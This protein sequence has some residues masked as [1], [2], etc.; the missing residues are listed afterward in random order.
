MRFFSMKKCYFFFFFFT[1]FLLHFSCKKQDITAAYLVLTKE[2]FE[3]CVNVDNFNKVHEQVYD[4]LELASIKQHNFRDVM[5]SINGTNLGYWQLPCKIPLLPD[6]SGKN[7]IRVTPCA[8]VVNTTLTATPYYFVEPIERFFD[9]EKEEIIEF[10]NAKFEYVRGVEFPLLE[11]FSQTTSFKPVDTV[12]TSSMEIHYDAELKKNVGRVL[13]EDTVN[14]FNVASKYFYLNSYGSRHFWEMNYKCESGEIH[15]Y[16]EFKNAVTGVEY[17]AMIIYPTT[18]KWKKTYIDL[19]QIISQVS[20]TADRVY[21]RLGITG[22]SK[23]GVSKANFYFDNIKLIT[24]P[25]PY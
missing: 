13:L 3:D 10:K 20:G 4:S 9:I 11:T 5:V 23:S 22:Y 14:F 1:I 18:A 17:Q 12:F 7:N 6:Y 25:A 24:M 21:V 8:R 19:S 16:L 15:T 2:D